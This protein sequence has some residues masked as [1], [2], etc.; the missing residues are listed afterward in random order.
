MF[1]LELGEGQT[2]YCR[3][4]GVNSVSLQSYMTPAFAVVEMVIDVINSPLQV[5]I[6]STEPIDAKELGTE[7]S[8]QVA[9]DLPG[10]TRGVEI[11]GQTFTPITSPAMMKAQ[12]LAREMPVV[13]NYPLTGAS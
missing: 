3:V 1:G 11:A 9:S 8:S 4:R 12:L 2:F 5:R 7:I 13:K 6:Y 10:A